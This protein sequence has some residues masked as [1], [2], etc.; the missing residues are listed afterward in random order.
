MTKQVSAQ[1]ATAGTQPPTA[2][3]AWQAP[4]L[5][6]TRYDEHYDQLASSAARTDHWTEPFKY[7]PVGDDAYLTTGIELRARNETYHNNLW[8]GGDAPDDSYLWLR[9][10][11]Y[12]DLHIGTGAIGA[13]A[14]VQPILAYAI[15]VAPSAGPV[16]QTRTDVLQ[17]FVD[18]RLGAQTNAI[19]GAGVTLRAGRQML[20]LGTE[21]LVG[22]RY[23]PNVPLAFD[24]LRGLVSLKGA[25]ITLLA[26]RPVTPGPGTFDDT[27]SRTKSLWGVYATI[28][29]I[30]LASGIDVYWLGYRNTAAR[31][32]G[33]NGAEQRDSFG[34]RLFGASAGWHWNVEGVYQSGRFADEPISAWTIG[35]EAG[36]SFADVPLKPDAVLRVNIVS[37]DR[38]R[39]DKRL[40][41]FNALFPKG[42]YFGELSPVG[43]YNII[44]VNPRVAVALASSVSASIAGMAYWRYSRAD[45]VYDIPGNLIRAAGSA[46]AR[47]IGKE[48]EATLAWQATPELELSTSLSAFA[49]GGFIRQTG[50]AK[51]ITMLGLETNF[52][53]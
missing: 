3:E 30:G 49:P 35:T 33:V 34:A 19:D 47:F 1:T 38:D 27:R 43:P 2:T 29:A 20:S 48:A 41:T 7:I 36:H 50:S 18:L 45:G 14:F 46:T 15:G 16:D 5:T 32:G 9:A 21:R 10:M 23:G 37:G 8:G 52:R 26:V 11:P 6:I 44:S 13:R 12:A 4:T 28:P 17:G 42:K 22:T 51:T 31:Y 40:N 39:D 24:G 25:T 53:F